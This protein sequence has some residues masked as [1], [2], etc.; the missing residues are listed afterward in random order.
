MLE[1]F[2]AHILFCKPFLHDKRSF[3][4]CSMY[5][6]SGI[7][8][9]KFKKKLSSFKFSNSVLFCKKTTVVYPW[10]FIFCNFLK[11]NHALYVTH[12][13]GTEPVLIMQ[14]QQKI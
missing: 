5:V 10:S 13:K 9:T 4:K 3:D 14:S 11:E 6:G 7:S 12:Q 1:S 2:F 8:F